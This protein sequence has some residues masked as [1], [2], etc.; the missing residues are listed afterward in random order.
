CGRARVIDV[1]PLIGTTS[2]KNWPASPEITPD[3]IKAYE[4]RSGELMPG[5]V[6]VLRSSHVDRYLRPLP[7]GKALMVDPLNGNSEGWPALGPDAVVYLDSKKI[8]CVAT[9]SP[10]L[11]GVDERRALQ[12]YWALGSRGIVGVEFLSNLDKLP[13]GAYFLFA[14]CKIR[15]CHG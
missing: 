15:D 1:T 9:D 12:A 14:A 4:A 5:D 13:E 8:R 7:E 11:G 6:V 10:T 3:F 2:Q